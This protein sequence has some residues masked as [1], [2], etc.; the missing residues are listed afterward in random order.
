MFGMA[1]SDESR[2]NATFC[3]ELLRGPGK[4]E[5]RF[6]A[7]FFS[8]VNVA[9][10]HRLAD[11]CA[12][13][14]RHRFLSGETRSQMARRE[15]HRHG[16]FNLAVGENPMQKTLSETIDRT[17]NARTLHKVNTDSND[18]HFATRTEEL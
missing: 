6:A 15:F 8:D 9:P 3:S 12:E 4:Y 13:R 5:K 16:V 11:P 2:S 7:L 17:L 14:F 18:A 10:T 1:E